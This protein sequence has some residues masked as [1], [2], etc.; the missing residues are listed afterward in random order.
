MDRCE[1]CERISACTVC[2]HRVKGFD[3]IGVRASRIRTQDSSTNVT[4]YR[5]ASGS[6]IWHFAQPCGHRV[7]SPKTSPRVKYNGGPLWKS[8]YA[9]QS[10][11]WGTYFETA[12][13]AAWVKR[14]EAAVLNIETDRTYSVGLS[15]YNVGVG[16]V[17]PQTVIK[18]NPSTKLTDS[19]IKQT[20]SNWISKGAVS[21]LGTEGAYNIFLPPGTSVSL[22]PLEVSCKVFCD[23]HNTV[24]GSKGP[25]YTVEPYPC[26]KGCNHCTNDLFDTLTQGL[27]EE[28]VELKTDMDPG[29]GWVIGNEELCD[30]CD[31]NFVCNRIGT[32]EYVNSWYDKSKKACWRGSSASTSEAYS[33]DL[34]SGGSQVET[35]S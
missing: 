2:G 1:A 16:R 35:G 17:T 25:F 15:E 6:G 12:S 19:Q 10:I 18:T 32:G 7:N 5:V 21:S 8:G 4:D 9:W 30:Y 29:T 13:G 11:Y 22:S 14:T 27:S 31:T 24:N 28:M 33:A 26:A 3:H 34:D 23:Y 20:L